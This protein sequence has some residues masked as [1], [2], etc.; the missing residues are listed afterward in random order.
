MKWSIIVCLLLFPSR[1]PYAQ[2]TVKVRISVK[3]PGYT[4]KN[5]EVFI[6]GDK[7]ELG[8]WDPGKVRLSRNGDGSYG[9][10]LNALPG[11]VLEYKYTRGSWETVE[12]GRDFSELDNRRAAVTGA[13]AINDTVLNWTDKKAAAKKHTLTG[14]LKYH[15]GF[16]SRILKNKRSLLVWLPDSYAAAKSRRY[17][18]IY[19]HDGQNVF[20]GATSFMGAEWEADEAAAAL[21]NG[22][23]PLEA[24][25][26]GIDNNAD[27]VDEYTPH[28]DAALGGG[29][30][31]D[32]AEFVVK[33][34]KPFIDAHYRTLSGRENTAVAG[35]SLG[36]LISLYLILEYPGAFSKAAVLSPS[37]YWA[38]GS[39]LDLAKNKADPGKMRIWLSM[40]TEEGDSSAE[41]KNLTESV[42]DSR[43][44]RDILLGKGFVENK[45][46][47]YFEEA[48]GRHNEKYWAK[49]LP[50]VFR[51][52]LL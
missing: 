29:K 50:E 2:D 47:V 4:P 8:S 21:A 6:V 7:P 44:L 49:I 46:L 14:T 26:V 52:L 25:I 1:L 39:L 18:V 32:Y 20:D 24:I 22:K 36:G 41:A 12:K 19:M 40:G 34:V 45:D 33:E 28:R 15:R 16:S 37:L 48:G 13:A 5:A 3:V 51:F 35:S 9:I 17:P 42:L 27:R 23:P 10:E 31:R 11:S 38:G 43:K 30:G